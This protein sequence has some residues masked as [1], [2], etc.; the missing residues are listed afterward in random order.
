LQ[1]DSPE[2]LELLRRAEAGAP[3]GSSL[4]VKTL[5]SQASVLAA[6]GRQDEVLPLLQRAAELDPS[7]EATFVQPLLDKARRDR[8]A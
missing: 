7:V 4:L 6:A 1:A 2:A 3:A 5:V 8:N